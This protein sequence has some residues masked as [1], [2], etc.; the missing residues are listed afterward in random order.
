M[1]VLPFPRGPPHGQRLEQEVAPVSAGTPL[2]FG[3]RP[4]NREGV[5]FKPQTGRLLLCQ[6]FETHSDSGQRSQKK[7]GRAKGRIRYN[8]RL[9]NMVPTFSNEKGRL[10]PTLKPSPK[11]SAEGA[12]GETRVLVSNEGSRSLS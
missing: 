2:C 5:R 10:T 1:H 7:T 3:T 11:P 8:H 9:V 12:S 6:V 4:R